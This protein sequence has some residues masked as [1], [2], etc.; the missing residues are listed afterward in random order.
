VLLLNQGTW[1]SVSMVLCPLPLPIQE[2]RKCNT[3]DGSVSTGD[4]NKAGNLGMFFCFFC[5]F[6]YVIVPTG[7][8]SD[9]IVISEIQLL[10]DLH[11]SRYF[12]HYIVLG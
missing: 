6:A 9:I 12:P 2:S 10:T 3:I 7:S 5:T 1:K 8:G 4:S 11:I